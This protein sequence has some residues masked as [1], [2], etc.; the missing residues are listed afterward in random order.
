MPLRMI[1]LATN[2]RHKVAEITGILSVLP[3]RLLSAKDFPEFPDPEETGETLEQN[4]RIKA[5]EVFAA[6]GE[7]AVADD[8]GLEVDALG[9]RPGVHSARFAGP[10]CSFQDNM[11]KLLRLMTDV[12][13]RQ[14]TARFRTVAALATAES[15]VCFSGTIEGSITTEQRGNGGFGYDPIFFVPSAGQSLAE[16]TADAKNAISHRGEA[17]R[18]V[19]EH[20]RTRL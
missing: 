12:P 9:G 7:W 17:F 13:Q 15:T 3:I 2:N 16:V 5:Q 1:I 8:T 6:F 14:R 18:I 20:L 19:A 11:Q 4:A 10:Q